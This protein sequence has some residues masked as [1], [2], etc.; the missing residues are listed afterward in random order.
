MRRAGGGEA[1]TD[2]VAGE[3]GR[4][5]ADLLADVGRGLLL[6]ARQQLCLDGHLH[7]LSEAGVDL[8]EGRRQQPSQEHRRHL[9]DLSTRR[10]RRQRWQT[11]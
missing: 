8:L 2:E 10:H 5:V 11:M 6:D 4:N 9:F 1:V 7:G 3:L